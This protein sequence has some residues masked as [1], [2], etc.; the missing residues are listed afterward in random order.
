MKPMISMTPKTKALR[1]TI[2]ITVLALA[3]SAI[4]MAA[5]P[6]S[7]TPVPAADAPPAY[8][9]ENPTE[10]APLKLR[11]LEGVVRGLG[12]DAMPR[13]SVSLFTEQGHQLI[14]TTMS[15]RAGKFH[16]AKMDKGL[17]RILVRVQGLCPAN[18]PVLLGSS[19]LAHR[20]LVVTMRAKDID[21]CSYGMT[22]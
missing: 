4:R 20:K 5:Q 6:A 15:D 1:T 2:A 12:G 9:N 14:A 17:Y 19:L 7:A 8:V 10:P 3:T 11:E 22:K 16:F 13:A 21:T 18:V